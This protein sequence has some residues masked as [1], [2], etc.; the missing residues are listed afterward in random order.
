MRVILIAMKDTAKRPEIQSILIQLVSV[1]GPSLL[2]TVWR[3]RSWQLAM[4]AAKRR[5]KRV[6]K[7]EGL[8]VPFG[9]GI[10][11]TMRCN[12]S[13]SGCYARFHS[14]EEEM[15][16]EVIDCL[17]GEASKAGV[18]LF[19][20]T[21]GEPY[22]REEMLDIY[23]KYSSSLFITVSNGSLFTDHL[24]GE[25]K[26]A[27]NILP[28]LSIEGFAEHT[29]KRRGLGVHEKVLEAMGRLKAAKM[30]FG[31]SSVLSKDAIE[32]LGSDSFVSDM[33]KRGAT[34]G[35]YNDFVPI[36]KDDE[37]LVPDDEEMTAFRSR[38]SKLRSRHPIVL[39]HLPDDEY[40]ENGRCTA[41]KDGAVHV[42]AQGDVEP[43]PFAHFAL[44]NVKRNTFRDILRSP[45]LEA[46]RRH[47][48][49]LTKCGTGCSLSSKQELLCELAAQSGARS[50]DSKSSQPITTIPDG[51]ASN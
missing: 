2:A 16:R 8:V 28:I 25:I 26:K 20:I 38:L 48:S 47:P 6:L 7:R 9:I 11:P 51:P 42:N 33:V 12:L 49:A 22:M 35:F 43:C 40:D 34:V 39:L 36:S 50:T 41:V 24:V 14:K 31:F 3:T 17:I 44:E 45:F 32:T 21:G 19:V 1:W 46:I 27:G 23:R 10:S 5:R 37:G 4:L 15:P 18:F 30:L 29:D 13:C